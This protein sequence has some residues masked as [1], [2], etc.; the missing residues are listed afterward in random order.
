[1]AQTCKSFNDSIW[2]LI[3]ILK[4]EELKNIKEV[5]SLAKFNNLTSLSFG[6]ISTVIPLPD[7]TKLTNLQ[8]LNAWT[9]KFQELN[10]SAIRIL[11]NL[12]E[13]CIYYPKA[14][15]KLADLLNDHRRLT[16]L[17][18]STQNLQKLGN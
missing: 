18:I 9:D 7:L 1:M 2:S 11:T 16:K 6:Y 10:I 8:R 15:E 3:T 12:R 14:S 4:S 13:L 17:L 5:N